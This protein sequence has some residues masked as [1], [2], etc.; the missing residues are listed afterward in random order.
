MFK[1]RKTRKR[2]TALNREVPEG[3]P[4]ANITVGQAAKCS[5]IISAA[6]DGH[7]EYRRPLDEI[8]KFLAAAS[9]EGGGVDVR[10]R[11][12][13]HWA[14]I[15]TYD[16]PPQGKGAKK[17]TK[18]PIAAAL[19][20]GFLLLIVGGLIW[21][22]SASDISEHA[23]NL[24]AGASTVLGLILLAVGDFME[25]W[26][27]DDMKDGDGKTH[28]VRENLMTLGHSLALVGGAYL[29]AAYLIGL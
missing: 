27:R 20:V 11:A 28:K 23:V 7:E 18:P 21:C 8:R 16:W 19:S 12:A 29:V 26:M 10:P 14:T 5:A 1:S 2:D 15:D 13:D 22:V 6:Q 9:A 25:F 17:K 3:D 24:L 4:S